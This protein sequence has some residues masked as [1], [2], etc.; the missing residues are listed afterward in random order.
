LIKHYIFQNKEKNYLF[1]Q[2]I[3]IFEETCKIEKYT[4]KRNDFMTNFLN[5]WNPFLQADLIGVLKHER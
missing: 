4:A 3:P 5:K 2:I 1:D